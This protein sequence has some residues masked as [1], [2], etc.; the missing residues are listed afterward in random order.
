MLHTP[1]LQVAPAPQTMPQPPQLFWSFV[2]FT[3]AE[4][5]PCEQHMPASCIVVWQV[6]PEN[7]G[8]HDFGTHRPPVQKLSPWQPPKLQFDDAAA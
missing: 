8:V 5:K 2:G 1:L 7:P 6:P 3:Q 4:L